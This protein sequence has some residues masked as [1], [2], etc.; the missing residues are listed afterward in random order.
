MAHVQDIDQRRHPSIRP[1]N[2][3]EL[4][5]SF[6]RRKN[7]Y[8]ANNNKYG[9][10][11]SKRTRKRMREELTKKGKNKHFLLKTM[12]IM[13]LSSSII[14]DTQANDRAHVLECICIYVCVCDN[15]QQQHCYAYT[16]PLR[17][18]RGQ[19]TTAK[20]SIIYKCCLPRLTK[21]ILKATHYGNRQTHAYA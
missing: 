13:S 17:G 9:G 6:T 8:L 19:R 2:R 15:S 11:S 4:V 1:G 7:T 18:R 20:K 12:N 10:S 5:E 3:S 21:W 16:P 14:L